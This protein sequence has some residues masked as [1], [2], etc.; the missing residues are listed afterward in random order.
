MALINCPE[1]GKEN[2]S[3]SAEACPN[4]GYG[5]KA[6]FEKI[7]Q[8]EERE[9]QNKLAELAREKAEKRKE[10]R[11]NF[12]LKYKKAFIIIGALVIILAAVNVGMYYKSMQT[13][14]TL[15]MDMDEVIAVLDKH[16]YEY[17]IRDNNEN[18][19]IVVQDVSLNNI[20]GNLYIEFSNKLISDVNF[21]TNLDNVDEKVS[22]LYGYLKRKYGNPIEITNENILKAFE[23]LG[24]DHYSFQSGDIIIGMT[25]PNSDESI[26]SNIAVSWYVNKK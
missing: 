25:Y 16:Q 20:K 7:K 5:I 13:D 22:E 17:E 12:I 8:D 26:R 11:I 3:D 6:H 1:C 23:L 10:K 24:E 14:I 2:V 4:C 18:V 21:C 15:G 19:V 9:R